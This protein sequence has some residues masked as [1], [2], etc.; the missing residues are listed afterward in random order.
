MTETAAELIADIAF[1]LRFKANL[2]H[3][4]ERAPDSNGAAA[5]NVEH[6][7]LMWTF[8]KS[9]RW[10]HGQSGCEC[11]GCLSLGALEPRRQALEEVVVG[12]LAAMQC[13]RN[14]RIAVAEA[15]GERKVADFDSGARHDA[16]N[17][18]DR[19]RRQ[20]AIGPDKRGGRI[21][22]RRTAGDPMLKPNAIGCR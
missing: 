17:V 14:V 13:I 11:G 5:K 16:A 20:A 22:A 7:S 19:G 9:R 6:L 2:Q 18:C 21:L 8:E 4:H 15:K 12:A 1:A 3:I 10:P